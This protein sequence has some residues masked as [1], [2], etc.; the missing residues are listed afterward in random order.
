MN[1]VELIRKKRNGES[2]TKS[3]IQFLIDSYL[4]KKIP[5]YQFSAFLMAVYFRGMTDEEQ[6]ALTNAMI[7]SG[8]VVNLKNIKGVKVD[9]HSTGG[10]GDKTSLIIAPIAAAAGVKVP[11]ISGRGL[12]HTGGTLDKLEAIPGFR[13]DLSLTEY[14][15]VLR[16][17]G[18]V[19]IG[20]TK[21]IAPADKLIYALRDVTAT[22]ESIPLITGSIMSKKIA[23]GIDGLVLDVKTGSGAFMTKEKDALK[24]ADSLMRTAKSFDKKV[25]T[26]ITD[27]NQPLGNYIGNW[28]EVYES[29]KVLQGENVD[30]LLEL[31]INL[32][33]AMI[34]LSKKAGSIKEGKEISL[35]LIKKGKAFDKL[36]EIVKLQKGDVKFLHKP[37]MYPKSK[38]TEKILSP[39]S[40]YL[41][42]I[43]NF[44]IGIAAL[45]LGAGRRTKEDKI[46]P[47]AGIIFYPKIGNQISK[48]SVIAEVYTDD[49]TKLKTAKSKILSSLS[50]SKTL[51]SKPKLI[52]RILI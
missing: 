37:E 44:E 41:S 8:I 48:N 4:K 2:L 33:G 22:V 31:S 3:E 27:M 24:L 36:V 47:K 19:L 17:C 18:A 1:T 29:I 38:Y 39:Q 11:M 10:V 30:D 42:A 45:E 15:N 14:K 16:K 26:F 40:G 46:D 50:F 12:G 23:E 6:T 21:E 32:S 43:N 28:F 52:K 34:Y 49:K 25:I 35:E 13:T 7:N 5:D 51:I 9:K 20:Q